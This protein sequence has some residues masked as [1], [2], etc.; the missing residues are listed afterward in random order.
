MQG[1]IPGRREFNMRKLMALG[2]VL[3]LTISCNQTGL[4]EEGGFKVRLPKNNREQVEYYMAQ[5]RVQ[6]VPTGPIVSDHRQADDSTS[7]DIVVPPMTSGGGNGTITVG[8]S[9]SQA[10]NGGPNGGNGVGGP[11]R[12]TIPGSKGLRAGGGSFPAG[13]LPTSRLNS[14]LPPGGAP[15]APR[16]LPGGFSTGIYGSVAPAKSA[17]PNNAVIRV[18]G[19]GP[20][21]PLP[22]APTR[23]MTYQ[24]SPVSSSNSGG[25]IVRTNVNGEVVKSK[26]LQR[27]K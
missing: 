16:G 5:P 4:A 22:A 7:Y 14:N 19:P 8:P 15:S 1:G 11:G 12:I 20:G 10:G 18:S 9:G 21:T 26:L 23:T 25:Q 6:I 3:P 24:Q 13:S 27:V 2:F 17:V